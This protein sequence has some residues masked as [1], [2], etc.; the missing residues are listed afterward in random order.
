MYFLVTHPI[1]E[2]VTQPEHTLSGRD[3]DALADGLKVGYFFDE[4]GGANEALGTDLERAERLLE[5]FFK[6]AA[7]GHRLADGLHR[8]RQGGVCPNKFFESETR[9]L[10][11]HVVNGRL[12]AGRG[13][14]GDIVL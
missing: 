9:D 4:F 14:A 7:D 10:G 13:L 5:R 12:K 2:G 8:R 3:R 1:E 11:D 6:S